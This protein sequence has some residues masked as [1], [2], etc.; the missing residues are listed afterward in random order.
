M[1]ALN[2][3]DILNYLESASILE[4][5]ELIKAIEVYNRRDRRFGGVKE[6]T[7]V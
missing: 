1:A 5:N 3:E 6:V 2:Q 4:L 7:N